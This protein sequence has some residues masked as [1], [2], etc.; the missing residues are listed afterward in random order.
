[1]FW[2]AWKPNQ[3]AMPAAASR[4][5]TSSVRAAIASARQITTPSS[6]I[7]TPAPTRPSSSPATVKTK[8]VC[9][10]GTNPARVCEPSK[11]PWPNS[12]PLPTAI[13][14]CSTL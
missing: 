8:S 1:M 10:S 2:N 11:S 14:A 12:P 4:P 3:Q 9:C 13:R 6:A 7:S 5:K